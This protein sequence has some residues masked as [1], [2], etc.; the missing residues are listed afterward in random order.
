MSSQDAKCQCPVTGTAYPTDSHHAE[1]SIDGDDEGLMGQPDAG[2]GSGDR[3]S[4]R[5]S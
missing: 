2:L 3:R 5:R 4:H 1:N